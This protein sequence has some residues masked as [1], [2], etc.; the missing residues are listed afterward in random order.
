MSAINQ[1]LLVNDLRIATNPCVSPDFCLDWPALAADIRDGGQ[2]TDYPQSRVETSDGSFELVENAAGDHAWIFKGSG[3]PLKG[4]SIDLGDGRRAFPATWENL[5]R[6]K[7]LIQEHNPETTVFPTATQRLGESTIGVGARFTTL[8]WPGVDW[9]MAQ[10]GIGVTANQNSIPR[11]LVYDVDVMLAGKLDRVPF[12]FIGTDV[13]EGHQGQSVEGMSHGCVLAKLKSGFHRRGIAWSF[14]ADHQPI[15]GA[16]DTREDQLVIGC[17]LAS[18][19]TFDLSPELSRTTLPESEAA[20]AA[21]VSANVA[22]DL[23]ARVKQRVAD[24]GL[25]L[26]EA[27]FNELL[28]RV[29]PSMKKMKARDEKYRAIRELHFTTSTG[30]AYLRELSID[31]LPG[32]TTPETTAIMLALCEA[33]GMPVQFVAPAFGFQK[34]MP[35]PDNDAL[36]TMISRQWDVCRVFGVSIGFHSGSGKSAENYRVMGEVTGGRLEI[37]TSGRYT[38]EMGRALFASSDPGDQALWRD[39]YGFTLE[40]AVAGAF[41]ESETERTMARTFIG[42]SFK[43]AGTATPEN[44]FESP[45]ACRAALLSLTPDPE[46]MFWF[47]YNVLYVLAADGRAEKSALGDHSA[48]G[49]GQ[50]ARFYSISREGRLRF[51][52]NVA[53]YIIFL[54]ET[55]GIVPADRCAAALAKLDGYTDHAA[56]LAD[57]G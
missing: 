51:A 21:Y 57:I 6:L 31:E 9:A 39:W 41:A 30:R 37:K 43:T 8:H 14:N 36:R 53:R 38:Y 44:L 16:F 33:M 49:Y 15:G 11:E 17:L 27:Q 42:E 2:L 47:E 4:D 20:Q 25:A 29:W 23:V 26:D 10:L 50:R 54:C 35:Y 1:F 34:N 5:L 7:N 46:F 52:S 24:T 19:I 3:T 12:P 55:T 56:F 40:L 28:C 32:L 22:A 48:A 13:P 45:A 18:Y